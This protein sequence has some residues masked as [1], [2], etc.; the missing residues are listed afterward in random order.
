[1]KLILV[2]AENLDIVWKGVKNLLK[3][4]IDLSNG[5]HTL[6]STYDLLKKGIM[7]LY[8]LVEK[9]KITSAV[10]IQQVLYPA[11]KV[12]GVL[13]AGGKSYIK[14]YDK[15]EKFFIEKA[16]KL[17]CSAI[18]IIVR[19]GLKRIADKTK[20]TLQSKGIFYEAEVK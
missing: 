2:D 18:E 6:T 16:R 14:H 5:R 20:S 19:K 1:M 9:S 4:P 17:N 15:L 7:Q 10:V 8:V 13:F 12:L 3:K 11:K